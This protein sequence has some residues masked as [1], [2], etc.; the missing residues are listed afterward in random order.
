MSMV[1]DTGPKSTDMVPMLDTAVV[2]VH[3]AVSRHL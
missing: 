1:Q 3:K 2:D